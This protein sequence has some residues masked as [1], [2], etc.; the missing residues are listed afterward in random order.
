MGQKV[1][2]T[3]SFD[4]E[5][6]NWYR[7][8]YID[9]NLSKTLNELLKNYLYVSI[10][11]KVENLEEELAKIEQKRLEYEQKA[12]L[13]KNKMAEVEKKA[14]EEQQKLTKI[15]KEK[16]EQATK[17]VICGSITN[18]TNRMELGKEKLI[19]RSCFNSTDAKTINS[20]LLKIKEGEV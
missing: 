2:K 3:L 16:E 8:K 20:L 6:I 17:C 13:L 15:A 4:A 12:I 9:G 7:K 14:I 1:N 5:I 10:N 19:H 18:E 11:E